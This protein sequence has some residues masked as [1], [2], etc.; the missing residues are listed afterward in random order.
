M[1][2]VNTDY[3]SMGGVRCTDCERVYGESV[4]L[5]RVRPAPFASAFPLLL[6]GIVSPR[7]PCRTREA[8]FVL[9]KGRTRQAFG[10]SRPRVACIAGAARK[11]T[12]NHGVLWHSSDARVLLYAHVMYK[13]HSRRSAYAFSKLTSKGTS[14]WSCS[15]RV[16]QRD[17]LRGVRAAAGLWR[18]ATWKA[19]VIGGA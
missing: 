10:A 2:G 17:G 3:I 9:R 15:S 7:G 6:L 13:R 4:R 5:N 1:Y 19:H 16:G 18:M 11:V 12:G 8:H 14:C